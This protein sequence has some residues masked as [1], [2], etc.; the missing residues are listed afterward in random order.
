MITIVRQISLGLVGLF[1]CPLVLLAQQARPTGPTA[2]E[3]METRQREF[4]I[5]FQVNQEG[6]NPPVEVHLMVS[7]DQGANWSQYRSEAPSANRFIFQTNNDGEYWFAVRTMTRDGKVSSA[8][9]KPELKVRVDTELPAVKLELNPLPSGEII[10]R[11]MVSDA[12]CDP[13]HVYLSY[14]TSPDSQFTNVTVDA[15]KAYNQNNVIAGE[16]RWFPHASTRYLMVRFE[17]HDRAGN[18]ASAQQTTTVPLVATRP[19]WGSVQGQRPVPDG[20]IYRGTPSASGPQDPFRRRDNQLPPSIPWPTDNR[21]PGSPAAAAGPLAENRAPTSP[22]PAMPSAQP[23]STRMISSTSDQSR[24]SAGPSQETP[25]SSAIEP[26]VAGPKAPEPNLGLPPGV[27]PEYVNFKKFELNYSVDAVG[28]SGIGQVE[29]W[30]TRDGGRTWEPGGI[31]PDQTSPVDVEVQTEGTYGFRV[32]VE[33]GNGL[34]GRRP[35]AGSLADIWIVVDETPPTAKIANVVYGQGARVGQLD[36]EWEAEDRFL[37]E[38]AISI[39]YAGSPEGPWKPVAENLPNDR[40]FAWRI[41]PEVP[42]DIYLKIVATDAAGNRH[43]S[44]IS[45]P[46]ANDGLTPQGKIRSIKPSSASP[47]QASLPVTIR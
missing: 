32:V 18:V 26:P 46:I 8:V 20:D 23:V 43:E 15:S 4:A 28:P 19:Q 34:T 35:Q 21:P 31:D 41:T 42:A 7:N 45:R 13:Q 1:L 39:Y 44:K 16:T 10:A 24:Y 25:V 14:Q 38:K 33:G 12:L 27:T 3:V 6:A 22:G 40:H 9:Q 36:I 30:I 5:P 47:S 2:A 29:L 37:G 17:A 11:W